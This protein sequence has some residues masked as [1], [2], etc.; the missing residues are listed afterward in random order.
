MFIMIWFMLTKDLP[1]WAP[2]VFLI[3]VSL[4]LLNWLLC[5]GEEEP[6]E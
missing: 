4:C 5:Q 3:V 1:Y 2:W 6:H